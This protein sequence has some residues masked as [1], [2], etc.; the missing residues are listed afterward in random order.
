EADYDWHA[1]DHGPRDRCP[2][3][4]HFIRWQGREFESRVGPEDEDEGFAECSEIAGEE[5]E[6]VRHEPSWLK[7]DERQAAE[8]DED[9]GR[10]LRDREDVV[11]AARGLDA[12]QI[13]DEDDRD[14]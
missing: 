11:H 14:D 7:R 4:D 10:Q 5:R 8:D 1:G 2:W 13:R 3:F 12:D 6:G 9:E